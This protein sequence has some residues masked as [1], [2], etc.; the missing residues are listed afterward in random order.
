MAIKR[1]ELLQKLEIVAPALA[2]HDLIPALTYILFTGTHL[3]AY[4]DS[5]GIATPLKTEFT[6]TIPGKMLIDFLRIT[7]HAAEV[8]ITQVNERIVEPIDEANEAVTLYDVQ[9]KAGRTKLVL[10][11]LPKAEYTAIFEMPPRP[12]NAAKVDE[13]FLTAIEDCLQATSKQ[14]VTPDHRGVTFIPNKQ[15]VKLFS[16]NSITISYSKVTLSDKAGIKQRVCLPSAFCQQMIAL[17]K[18]AE[19]C[20][21]VLR[22]DHALFM[23]EKAT[24][25]SR[26]LQSE[27]PL[28][29]EDTLKRHL[30]NNV[31]AFSQLNDA[32]RPR[33]KSALELAARICDIKGNEV[34]TRVRC[35]KDMMEFLSSSN[36]GDADSIKIKHAPVDVFFQAS[37]LRDVYD[38]YETILFSNQSVLLSRDNMN[39]VF[40]LATYSRGS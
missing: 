37:Y 11:A 24:L 31:S 7:A 4:N 6:G 27:N 10:N 35:Q 34:R 40:I 33:L 22:D 8:E 12:K 14:G 20:W 1:D 36:R 17:G 16:T 26:L 18:Q 32:Q 21:F 28:N 2:D 25:F 30:P 23:T 38:R 5:I 15:D 3:V 19:G 29:F 39:S 13:K 9:L